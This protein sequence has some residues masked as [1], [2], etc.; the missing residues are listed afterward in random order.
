M[1]VGLPMP[2]AM[3]Y[4]QAICAKIY[5]VTL[6]DISKIM[7]ILTLGWTAVFAMFVLSIGFVVWGRNGL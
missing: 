5:S 3:P 1:Y 4:Y 2:F 7:D 6:N